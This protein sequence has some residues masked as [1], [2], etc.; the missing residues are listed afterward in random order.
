VQSSSPASAREAEASADQ[1]RH[2]T[3]TQEPLKLAWF[4]YTDQPRVL[5]A[6]RLLFDRL[7]ALGQLR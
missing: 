5:T 7:K 3:F 4:G 2:G 1:S 6:D